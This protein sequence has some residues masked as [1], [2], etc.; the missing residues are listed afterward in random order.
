MNIRFVC[1]LD[2]SCQITLFARGHI[3]AEIFRAESERFYK[4]NFDKDLNAIEFP[5]RQTYWRNV[6]APAD[7]IVGDRQLVES[8]AG[9]GAFPVTI[10]DKILPM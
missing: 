7:N 1:A 5:V 2:D 9:P 10:L 6:K 4:S 8:K 3:K